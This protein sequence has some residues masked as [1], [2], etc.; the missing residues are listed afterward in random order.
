M[1][2]PIITVSSPKTNSEFPITRAVTSPVEWD[3]YYSGARSSKS[4]DNQMNGSQGLE[5]DVEEEGLDENFV[6]GRLSPV[7]APLPDTVSLAEMEEYLPGYRFVGNR[8]VEME[9]ADVEYESS[10]HEFTFEHPL[11]LGEDFEDF[12]SCSYWDDYE[13][14]V[15]ESCFEVSNGEDTDLEGPSEDYNVSNA[16]GDA[17]EYSA[18][19]SPAGF[20]VNYSGY[21]ASAE[22]DE[23]VDGFSGYE[24]EAHSECNTS[25]VYS[26]GS[27]YN[28]VIVEEAF[29]EYDEGQIE[30]EEFY[31][32]ESD[33]VRIEEPYSEVIDDHGTPSDDEMCME[34]VLDCGVC[35]GLYFNSTDAPQNHEYSL[36]DYTSQGADVE[37]EEFPRRLETIPEVDE[38]LGPFPY[39]YA[40]YVPEDTHVDEGFGAED[41]FYPDEASLAVE[42]EEIGDENGPYFNDTQLDL[43]EV[44]YTF[45]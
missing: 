13:A 28:G 39:G 1:A 21:Y 4:R 6:Y 29:E 7:P 17:P 41:D 33:D 14:D 42:E 26:D 44:K 19:E 12:S 40:E 43:A 16:Y 22:C 32:D 3:H 24:P 35:S 5:Y 18:S 38:S 34:Q 45:V 25:G 31:D 23:S 30:E 2:N 20:K 27:E 11:R 36:E 37:F 10:F 15:S 9:E 8:D